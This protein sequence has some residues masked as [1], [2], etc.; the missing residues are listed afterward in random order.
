MESLLE[1]TARPELPSAPQR[2]NVTWF[3]GWEPVSDIDLPALLG[4]FVSVS[5]V[6]ETVSSIIAAASNLDRELSRTLD[7]LIDSAREERFE[8]GMDS[9]FSVGLRVFFRDYSVEFARVLERRLRQGGISPRVLVELAYTLGQIRDDATVEWRL[10][11]L[12]DF[13]K[14]PTPSVKDAGAVGLAYLDDKRAV[15]YLREAMEREAVASFREDLRAVV[16]QLTA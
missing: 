2:S 12:V 13:L 16:E 9:N 7:T 3:G 11:T 14:S 4:D 5:T 15:P 10:A 8:D 1:T 6:S